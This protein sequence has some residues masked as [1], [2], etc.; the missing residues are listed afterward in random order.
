MTTVSLG[1]LR[2]KLRH[3]VQCFDQ[4]CPECLGIED[5]LD[6]EDDKEPDRCVWVRDSG[7][8][9]QSKARSS[10]GL[11]RHHALEINGGRVDRDRLKNG[12]RSAK[13]PDPSWRC[14]ALCVGT[15]VQCNKRAQER[16]GFCWAHRRFPPDHVVSGDE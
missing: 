11:C 7:R 12:G 4:A 8:R 10:D 9:C 3:A 14:Q 16:D 2:A 6:K 5:V 15:D 1:W 13:W